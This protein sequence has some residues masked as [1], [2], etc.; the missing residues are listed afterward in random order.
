MKY[1]I[2]MI[3]IGCSNIKPINSNQRENEKTSGSKDVK[4]TVKVPKL[5]KITMQPGQVTMLRMPLD[6]AFKDYE[7]LCKGQKL[8]F[9]YNDGQLLTFLLETYFSDLRPY[10]CKLKLNSDEIVIA[11]I[12]LKDYDYPLE[13]INVDM[14][15]VV[16]SKKDQ[17]RAWKEQQML[18]KLYAV[19]TNYPLFDQGFI[20]PLDSFVTSWYGKRRIFNNKKKSQHL[21]IDFRAKVGVKIPVTNAGRVIFSGD[22]F[23]T[24]KTVIVFHGLDIFSVYGHMSKL[25]V[26][27]GDMV[28]R[29]DVLGLS[30]A[31]GRVSGPHLHWGVK[32]RGQYIDGFS[33]VKQTKELKIRR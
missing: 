12:K 14:K 17:K 33:L 3:L 11:D 13:K 4:I 30:G 24:G 26:S 1:L 25:Q 22:L 32:I 6:P 16:L 19:R 21:G 20:K 31:T 9:Y 23:Y 15:R 10:Q 5:Q 2:F 8:E 18:N 27:A 7:L 28:K 29:G